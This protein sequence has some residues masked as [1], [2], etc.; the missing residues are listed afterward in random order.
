MKTRGK[1]LAYIPENEYVD[2]MIEVYLLYVYRIDGEL[3]EEMRLQIKMCSDKGGTGE[4]RSHK[5]H[6]KDGCNRTI[7]T[8][9]NAALDGMQN[10]TIL[11]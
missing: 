10:D 1:A 5:F 8:T 6:M 11:P 3:R 4:C 2:V 7:R 9:A